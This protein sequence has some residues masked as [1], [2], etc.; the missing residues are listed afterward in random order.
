M[1]NIDGNGRLD[2]LRIVL[3]DAI[4]FTLIFIE[5]PVGPAR[6]ELL[7]R[8]R[9]WSGQDEV[10]V[11]RFVALGPSESPWN[12][13]QALELQPGKRTGVV[14]TGLEQFSIGKGLAGPVH[15]LNLARDLLARTV[16]G[17]LVI[18]ADAAVLRAISE[19]MPDLYSWRSFEIQVRSAGDRAEGEG[20]TK[21]SDA[22]E[23]P[24]ETALEELER[25]RGL[26]AHS[27]ENS[28]GTRAL[29]LRLARAAFNAFAVD[30]AAATL[31][32]LGEPDG[33]ADTAF[34]AKWFK[35][36]GDIALRRSDHATARGRYEEALP[37][38]RG[39]GDVLGEANCIRSLGNIALARSDHPTAKA[40]YEEALPLYRRVG[41]VLGEA[42]CIHGLGDIARADSDH[43]TARQFHE[44]SLQLYRRIAEPYSV[45]RAHVYLAW[46]ATNDD[47]RARHRRLAREAWA[48]IGRDDLIAAH[49][50][51]IEE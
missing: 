15:A 9:A 37:L 36:S 7:G 13:L 19:Q 43:D 18:V 11:L 1:L 50:T 29:Q 33:A 3:E 34:A 4:R 14:L 10:P 51:E 17:P 30:E 25:L 16:P 39:L 40:R 35:L 23:M 44:Y 32:S 49:L 41:D 6:E 21:L 28:M 31:V 45:G 2:A 12:T 38:Y 46:L 42:N 20:A 5:A 8:L 48:S 27:P 24:R 22:L 47:E 26:V